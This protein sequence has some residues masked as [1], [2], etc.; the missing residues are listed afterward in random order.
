MA[1]AKFFV[2]SDIG[3]IYYRT[4]GTLLSKYNPT[5]YSGIRLSSALWKRYKDGI[6]EDRVELGNLGERSILEENQLEW[7]NIWMPGSP[8]SIWRKW[9]WLREHH[10]LGGFRAF[11]KMLLWTFFRGHFYFRPIRRWHIK[12]LYPH[13]RNWK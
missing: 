4:H 9:L 5:S 3:Y 1:G 12:R 2:A 13:A 10:E 7:R 8:Y 11:I 6:S